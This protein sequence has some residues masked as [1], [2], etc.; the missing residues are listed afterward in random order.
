MQKP[1]LILVFVVLLAIVGGAILVPQMLSEPAA[2]V[3]QWGLEDEI[4]GADPEAE[5]GDA[6]AQSGTIERT[7]VE[8]IEGAVVPADAGQRVAAILRGRVVDKFQQPVA[9]ARVWLEFGRAG[10]R[11]PRGRDRNRRIPE[12]VETDREGRF[13]FQG[14]TFRRLRVSL[15][16]QHE[17]HAPGLFDKD[18]GDIA[19]ASG[20]MMAQTAEVELG[21][22]VLKNGGQVRGRVVDL[23]GNG[24][25]N[26]SLSLEPDFRN[27]MRW[28]RNSQDL[29]PA[30]VTDTS[31][32]YTYTN[33]AEGDYV[34]AAVAKMHT[35]GRSDG[36]TVT[37]EQ[38]AEVA[39]IQL[40][41]GFELSG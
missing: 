2:P 19:D 41:P 17:T 32:F 5:Q 38:I 6:E 13:A 20:T 1:T 27:R 9:G 39:D 33:I 30:I 21:D 22:L 3:V 40:G 28:Q 34:V 15:Q 31:G 37:E 10:G 7:Q 12:P 4:E 16:V 35:E 8:P 23:A 11:N 18:L 25:P 24:V 14:Q 36:F 26:A 29:L